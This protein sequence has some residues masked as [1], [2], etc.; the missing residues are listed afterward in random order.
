MGMILPT[1]SSL[2]RAMKCPAS[3]ALPQSSDSG[4]EYATRGDVIHEYIQRVNDGTP[5]DDALESI[6]DEDHRSLCASIDPALLAHGMASEVSLAYDVDDGRGWEIGRN[7]SREYGTLNATT[8][9]GTADILGVADDSVHV[10]DIKTGFLP[11]TTAAENMQLRMLALA[12]CNAYDKPRATVAIVRVKQDG[13]VWR[14]RAEFDSFEISAIQMQM[15]SILDSVVDA[16]FKL[17]IGDQLSYT[18]GPHCR[19]CNAF[20]SCGEKTK[21][22]RMMASGAE[23]DELDQMM[24]LTPQM[25]AYAYQR[26]KSCDAMLKRI[27][28]AIYA[29]AAEQPIPLGDGTVLGMHEST[30]N[31]RIDGRIALK[32]IA[33]QFG[34]DVAFD[35]I[36]PVVT[37][38]RIRDIARAN[39]GDAKLVDVERGIL[40]AIRERGGSKKHVTRAVR[41]YR[42]KRSDADE[43]SELP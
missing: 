12:A 38:K 16:R 22:V 31:E 19:Y 30:G 3:A 9:V 1:A 8:F 20:T 13:T 42:P 6:E 23:F 4:S 35:A 21:L 24:P 29:L 7:L 2:E 18:E 37:K 11:V 27:R 36:D 41:E 39:R 28:G 40:A 26:V 34:K 33:E 15:I 10:A 5:I 25:A 14:D 32:V 43:P 17:S